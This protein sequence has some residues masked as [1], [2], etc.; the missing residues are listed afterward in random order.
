MRISTRTHAFLDFATAGFAMAF[1]RALGASARFTN[2]VTTVALTKIC[3]A[4]LTKHELGVFKVLPMKTHLVLDTIGGAA[5]CALPFMIDED[6]NCEVTAC[7]VG[8]GLFDIAAAPI[9]ETD[10]EPRVERF[11]FE[12]RSNRTRERVGS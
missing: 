4:L 12:E 1:P 7:A 5:L 8:L 9:T 2:I 6:E 10:Y 3:Y 11:S